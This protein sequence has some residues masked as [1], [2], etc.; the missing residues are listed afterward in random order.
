MLLTVFG[1]IGLIFILIPFILHALG[2]MKRK[3]ITYNLLNFI[4]GFI[5]AIY[6]FYLQNFIFLI[7]QIVWAI[8]SFY[9]LIKVIIK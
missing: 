9:F 4:G 2:E 6:S 3:T 5:L 1:A 8:T 7:L